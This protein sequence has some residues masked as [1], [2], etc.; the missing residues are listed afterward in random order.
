MLGNVRRINARQK[1]C[2]RRNFL[3]RI[4]KAE[5]SFVVR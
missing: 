4:G 5:T 2:T 1:I 3:V